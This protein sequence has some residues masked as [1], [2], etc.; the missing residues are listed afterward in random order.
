MCPTCKGRGYKGRIGIFEIAP[1]ALYEGWEKFIERPL[2]MRDFF[3][4]LGFHDLMGDAVEKI[5]LGLVSPDALA[6][7]LARMEAVIGSDA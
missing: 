5:K 2:A 4:S 6:G 1:L 3:L 7:V